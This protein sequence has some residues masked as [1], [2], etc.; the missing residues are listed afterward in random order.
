MDHD[1]LI[2]FEQEDPELGKV[3]DRYINVTRL[4]VS[5]RGLSRLI[6]QSTVLGIS[7][8]DMYGPK[9]GRN[10]PCSC[11]SERKFKQCC[12]RP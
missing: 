3:V 5:G 12:G 10:D 7:H 8:W 11:G 2:P 9:P 1:P 6:I 4:G